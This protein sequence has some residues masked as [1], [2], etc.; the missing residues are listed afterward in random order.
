MEYLEALALQ[1]RLGKVV[2]PLQSLGTLSKEEET[3]EMLGR[4]VGVFCYVCALYTK[5]GEF[6]GE[7]RG[8]REVARTKMFTRRSRWRRNPPR[9]TRSCIPGRCQLR[10]PESGGPASAGDNRAAA[11]TT[12]CGAPE[13]VG[14][15]EDGYSWL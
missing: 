10:R 8:A 4:P 9:L 6:V 11:E 13:A 5:R 1:S 7:G 3:W 2:A 14:A 15:W 12:D